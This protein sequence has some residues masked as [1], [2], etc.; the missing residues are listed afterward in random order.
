MS[1]SDYNSLL[2][3]LCQHLG[4][5]DMTLL[6]QAGI[7]RVGGRDLLLQYDPVAEPNL[8]QGCLDLGEADTEQREW[9]WYR[10]LISNFEWG[11]N[12][13]LGWGLTP[14][15]NNVILTAQ[16]AFD[17]YTTGAALAGWLRNLVT[18]TEAYWRALP[19]RQP[20]SELRSLA[21][22]QRVTRPG[23][24]GSASWTVLIEAFCDHV[25]LAERESLLNEGDTLSV[26]G[27]DVFLRQDKFA[28]GCFEVRIDLGVKIAAP[29]DKLWQGLLWS[30]FAMGRGGRTLF[31]V[32]P[33]KDTLMLM[34][35]QDLPVDVSAEDFAELLHVIAANAEQFWPKARD[36]M[37]RAESML[38]RAEASAGF[39]HLGGPPH[40]NI[41]FR[42]MDIL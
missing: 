31:S 34:L 21:P 37:S 41:V 5:L 40:G 1:F 18:R 9:I 12:G 2:T 4:V 27:V 38:R 32:H 8:I 26:D 36:M 30:N 39:R 6:R 13:I 10:L 42:K 3:Q 33:E 17:R 29:R 14:E 7:L 15:G 35:L 28:P 23:R 19:S 11:T 22:L 25:G 16:F 20:L 24:A